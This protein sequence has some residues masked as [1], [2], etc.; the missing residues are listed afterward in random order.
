[1]YLTYV[2]V[3]ILYRIGKGGV[4]FYQ[5]HKSEVGRY[6][7]QA[8]I[9]HETALSL[10]T[11]AKIDDLLKKQGVTGLGIEVHSDIGNHGKTKEL[12]QEVVS[13]I[14]A[15]GYAAQIKPESFGASKVADKYTD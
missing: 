14:N 6:S 3:I 8:A 4:Y 11:A 2:T 15:S 13:W 9:Y 10:A 7:L 12:I 1:E 5:R